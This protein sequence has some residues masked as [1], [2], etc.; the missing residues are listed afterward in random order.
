MRFLSSTRPPA[1]SFATR[2]SRS[3]RLAASLAALCLTATG[4]GAASSLVAAPVAQAHSVL[5]SSSPEQGAT[6]EASPREVTVTFNEDISPE[7]ATLTVMRDG[8]NEAEGEAKVDGATLS[9]AVPD[10]DPATYTVG[11]RVVSADGH[12]VQGSFDFSVAGGA[13]GTSTNGTGDADATPA[14]SDATEDDAQQSSAPWAPIALLAVLAV[15]LIG[16]AFYFLGRQRR[17]FRELSGD[18]GSGTDF[19]TDTDTG[20]NAD[21]AGPRA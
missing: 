15:A 13:A 3:R 4:A 7:F 8:T 19:D 21:G 16:G 6:V 1:T 12:P 18:P 14:D 10:L 9:V 20:E 11:Y 5:T 2:P 17:Q